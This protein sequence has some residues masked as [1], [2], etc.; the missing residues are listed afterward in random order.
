MTDE[1]REQARQQMHEEHRT[2][3]Q[4]LAMYARERVA[5]QAALEERDD[6]LRQIA[7]INPLLRRDE[8]H[9]YDMICRFGCGFVTD[10]VPV[11]AEEDAAHRQAHIQAAPQCP[12]VRAQTLAH[13]RTWVGERAEEWDRA[14]RV[15]WTQ[16]AQQRRRRESS[17]QG[18][19]G[20]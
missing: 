19:R 11:G 14:R 17:A 16:A 6:L 5:F 12:W 7:R 20:D 15:R 4:A 9:H 2:R 8:T 3:E 18:D 1:E 10:R 13:W